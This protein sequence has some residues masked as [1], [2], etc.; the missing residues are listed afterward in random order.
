MRPLCWDRTVMSTPPQRSP[1]PPHTH[2]HG[3]QHQ[4]RDIVL[5]DERTVI[6]GQHQR[7]QPCAHLWE[8]GTGAGTD[9]HCCWPRTGTHQARSGQRWETYAGPLEGTAH[10]GLAPQVR[11]VTKPS[12]PP[13]TKRAL[14]ARLCQATGCHRLESPHI[15]YPWDVQKYVPRPHHA[16]VPTGF[17]L[18]HHVG[19]AN[20]GPLALAPPACPE[21]P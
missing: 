11:P 19:H 17:A 2:R 6:G 1:A 15:G 18:E 4:S 8:C 16:T 9:H 20:P 13:P 3:Q 5:P 21:P 10:K 12:N 7:G 14:L